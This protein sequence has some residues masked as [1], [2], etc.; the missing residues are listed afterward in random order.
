[1]FELGGGCSSEES[2]G[3]SRENVHTQMSYQFVKRFKVGDLFDIYYGKRVKKDDWLD[4]DIPYVTAVEVNNGIDGYISN[5]LMLVENCLSL[6]FLGD[7]FY[8]PYQ[9]SMKD[10]TY[11]LK[12]KN[13]EFE[14][15]AV[16]LYLA[17]VLSKRTKLEATYTNPC[18]PNEFKD[19]CLTL[20]VDI[21]GIL[22]WHFMET[23]VRLGGGVCI[24]EESGIGSR[25]V[26]YS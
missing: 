22:D 2:G 11:G 1:M 18:R 3:G 24:T 17:T 26:I 21:S 9:F 7:V 20:P 8:H 5:P 19:V 13:S 15:K 4:G 12:L 6:S 10:G 23:Y 16:Y 25:E 14:T